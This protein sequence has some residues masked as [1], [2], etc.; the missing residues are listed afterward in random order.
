VLEVG[1]PKIKVSAASVSG[2]R[3][4]LGFQR[5]PFLPCDQRV[6]ALGSLFIR[7]FRIE[8]RIGRGLGWEMYESMLH[9]SCLHVACNLK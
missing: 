6:D 8:E 9:S 2:E 3:T 7:A 4:V 1:K 5:A